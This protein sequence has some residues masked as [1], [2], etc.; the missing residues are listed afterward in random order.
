LFAR[1]ER[2]L[3]EL[4]SEPDAGKP[5]QGPLAGLRSFR[6]G[7]LRIIY[8][9]LKDQ[10]LVFVLDIEQRGRVYRDERG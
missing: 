8:R 3:D 7:P 10:L 1:V 5:L 6:V 2:A 9:F 4:V